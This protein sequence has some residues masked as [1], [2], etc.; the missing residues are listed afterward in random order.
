MLSDIRTDVKASPFVNQKS[1]ID[2]LDKL[3]ASGVNYNLEQRA[4]LMTLNDRLVPTFDALD[5]AFQRMIR[6]QQADITTTQIGAEARLLEF[7]NGTFKDSSYLT[8][9]Y[10]SVS[11]AISEA[12]STQLDTD[13]YT[14]FGFAVQKWLGALYSVGMSDTAISSIASAINLLATGDVNQLGESPA[15]TLLAL[16]SQRAGLSYADLLT[17]GLTADDTDKLLKSMIEYLKSIA[18]NTSSKVVRSQWGDILNLQMSDWKAIQ[19]LTES[20]ITNLVKTTITQKEAS[21]TLSTLITE[22][23][24]ARTHL[25]E[26]LSNSLD[27]AL[28]SFGMSV[29]SDTSEELFSNKYAQWEML[30]FTRN[31]MSTIAGESSLISNITNLVTGALTGFRFGS[32]IAK[33][34]MDLGDALLGGT[35]NSILNAFS[36]NYSYTMNR[37]GIR[38]NTINNNSSVEYGISESSNNIVIPSDLQRLMINEVED[39]YVVPDE[40]L[41]IRSTGSEALLT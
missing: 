37:G 12:L 6:L 18:D 34:G 7:L 13:Q 2:N 20:D 16:S 23:I 9:M 15:Q 10:D 22:Y 33:I 11:N 17:Q 38:N 1:L 41:G 21:D 35:D 30:K 40:T 19:N 4:L 3:V 26:R 27:N 39:Y 25:S 29:A 14:R 32:D 8:S 24:P 31:M 36:R 28:I 5:G